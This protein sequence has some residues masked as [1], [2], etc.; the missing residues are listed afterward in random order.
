MSIKIHNSILKDRLQ[1]ALENAISAYNAS[2]TDGDIY[3]A[4][5]RIA[6]KYR[7]RAHAQWERESRVEVR[8]NE[9]KRIVSANSL[10]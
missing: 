10:Q 8:Q 7:V 5:T 1:E 3:L 6:E 9:L 2:V 4:V